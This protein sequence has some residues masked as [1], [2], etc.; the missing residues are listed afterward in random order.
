MP[1]NFDE[2]FGG[3][4]QNFIEAY[5]LDEADDSFVDILR[6]NNAKTQNDFLNVILKY[7]QETNIP[8]VQDRSPAFLK[9]YTKL[10]FGRSESVWLA[11]YKDL[12]VGTGMIEKVDKSRLLYQSCSPDDKP[13]LEFGAL[14][15]L[16]EF[17]HLNVEDNL[18]NFLINYFKENYPENYNF[19][20][21]SWSDKANEEWCQEHFKYLGDFTDETGVVGAKVWLIAST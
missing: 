6:V 7:Q 4:E 18:I 12:P 21:V 20:T 10:R 17:K 9:E 1:L 16:P 2:V 3:I 15:V 19:V 8:D 5:E 13:M 14:T 11:Y